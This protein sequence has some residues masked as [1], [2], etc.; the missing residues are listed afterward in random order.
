MASNR[1]KFLR[2]LSTALV[3]TGAMPYFQTV[4]GKSLLTSFSNIK[5]MPL[6]QVA[7]EEQFWRQVRLAYTVSSAIINLNNGGVSPQPKIVQEAVERYN[8]E[9]NEVPSYFMWRILNQVKE[10]IRRKLAALAGCDSEEIAINRNA[11]E[12][13]ETVIFGLQLQAGDEVVLTRQ[14]YPSMMNAW[15]QREKRDGL[16]LKWLDLKL[17]VEN[18]QL[19]VEQFVSAFGPK[20]KVV[21]LTHV[22][23]WNG[24][25]L[26]VREIADVAAKKGIQVLVDGAHSFA[27]LDFKIPDLNCDYFGTSLHKWLCAPFGSGMLYVRKSRIG[28]LYP[29]FAAVDPESEDIRKFEHLGTRSIAIELAIGQA[30]DFHKMIG[31][32]RKQARLKYLSKYYLDQIKDEQ[33]IKICTPVKPENA[34]AISLINLEGIDPTDVSKELWRRHKIHTTSINQANLAGVRITPNVYTL[35]EELDVLVTALK[36]IRAKSVKND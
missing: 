27:H 5:S 35:P 22:I 24:Q 18:K 8:Q 12:A 36:K 6:E 20:T 10:P 16:V 25:V 26:P 7:Q 9:S 21:H 1:R 3:G 14:D 29:L 34:C 15:K 30:I 17:P 33:G 31:A 19:L 28:K 13:L 11:S 32:E 23:N 4:Q 2:N